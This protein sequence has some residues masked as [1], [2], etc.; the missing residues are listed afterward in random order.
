LD[1]PG[2]QIR[3]IHSFAPT[4]FRKRIVLPSVNEC[5]QTGDL[6]F[7]EVKVRHAFVRSSIAHD[8]T[9]LVSIHI[10][11]DELGTR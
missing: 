1:I 4:G 8:R 7:G 10:S 9:Y 6:I 3:S 2:L 11:G 5:R